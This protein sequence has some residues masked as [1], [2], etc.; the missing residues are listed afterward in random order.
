MN[1][2]RSGHIAWTCVHTL[3]NTLR[4]KQRIEC[5]WL[6]NIDAGWRTV[7]ARQTITKTTQWNRCWN[8]VGCVQKCATI[9]SFESNEITVRINVRRGTLRAGWMLEQQ[10]QHH[11]GHIELN[12]NA[13]Q[14]QKTPG[15]CVNHAKTAI[16][17]VRQCQEMRHKK[18]SPTLIF[19]WARVSNMTVS[20]RKQRMM[21]AWPTNFDAVFTDVGVSKTANPRA[22]EWSRAEIVLN[23]C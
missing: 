14:M 17:P 18:H 20:V 5:R 8:R 9:L 16:W 13:T 11:V 23:L 2:I 7:G 3:L 6:T 10:R 19:V 12:A 22:Q 21:S 4:M 1:G 15:R